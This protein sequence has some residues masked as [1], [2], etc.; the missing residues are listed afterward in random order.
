MAASLARQSTKAA[1][2]TK[3]TAALSVASRKLSTSS[4]QVDISFSSSYSLSSKS[5]ILSHIKMAAQLARQTADLSLDSRNLLLADIYLF[6]S[7]Y[8]SFCG[9][10][11]S[12]YNKTVKLTKQTSALSLAFMKLSTSVSLFVNLFLISKDLE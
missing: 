1:Q 4:Q 9:V 3:Q 5:L 11:I 8:L 6:Y 12:P 2:L 10:H 7:R